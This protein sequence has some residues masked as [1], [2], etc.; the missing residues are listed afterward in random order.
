MQLSATITTITQRRPRP[1]VVSRAAKAGLG[2]LLITAASSLIVAPPALAGKFFVCKAVANPGPQNYAHC[3]NQKN[4][5][6]DGKDFRWA[7]FTNSEFAEK[8]NLSG[9]T[10]DNAKMTSVKFHN[11]NLTKTSMRETELAGAVFDENTLLDETDVTG[12]L[13][14]PP[15]K[16]TSKSSPLYGEQLAATSHVEDVTG[17]RRGICTNNRSQARNTPS[18]PWEKDPNNPN[19]VYHIICL[20]YGNRTGPEQPYGHVELTFS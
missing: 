9:M 18:P 8:L 14:V 7:D 13:L 17:I 10:L 2:A 3:D 19:R 6:L 1:R 20:V 5:E 11:N 16:Y 4:T 15:S 12:T